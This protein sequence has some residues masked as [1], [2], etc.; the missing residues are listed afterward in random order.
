MTLAE[1]CEK[2]LKALVKV[3]LS[4]CVFFFYVCVL[5]WITSVFLNLSA[6]V[7]ASK[8]QH[9]WDWSHLSEIYPVW[10]LG[11]REGHRRPAL[12]QRILLG[13]VAWQ[14][15]LIGLAGLRKGLAR[16]EGI[17][18][19]PLI[20]FSLHSSESWGRSHKIKALPS[21]LREGY[22]AH[23]GEE[24][25]I[26]GFVWSLSPTSHTAHRGVMLQLLRVTSDVIVIEDL[27]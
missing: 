19:L 1:L 12:S 14:H 6:T 13:L 18:S 25:D 21:C 26:A 8:R 4:V 16:A 20:I 24:R 7:A 17:R 3:C 9:S 5:F 27:P 15:W 22:Y 10:S 2:F 23:R 11:A